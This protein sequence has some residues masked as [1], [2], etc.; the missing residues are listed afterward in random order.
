MF[1]R[2]TLAFILALVLATACILFVP[3]DVANAAEQKYAYAAPSNLEG[4]TYAGA[5]AVPVRDGETE[6]VVF[7]L[8]ESYYYPVTKTGALYVVDIDGLN[9][10]INTSEMSAEPAAY[11]SVTAAN[12]L[13]SQILITGSDGITLDGTAVSSADGWT[14][15]LVGL[16]GTDVFVKAVKDDAVLYGS[17]PSSAFNSFNIN[18]HEI[19]QAER[20]GLLSAVP[21]D[22]SEVGAS[23]SG[24]QSKALRIVLIIGIIIPAVIIAILLFKPSR[25]DYDRRPGR[26]RKSEPRSDY[27]RDRRPR[28]YDRGDEYPDGRR[29]PDEYSDG[30]RYPDR[31]PDDRRYPDD[32]Y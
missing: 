28:D 19:A 25:G 2:T 17:A 9:A 23:G 13:P 4:N 29:Y 22:S 11:D 12:A 3:E 30:R 21:D 20:D 10:Y 15:R 18:Y 24:N 32:R 26:Q 14:V 6:A 8:I 5:S 7:Y 16:N 1:A 31:R 27:D